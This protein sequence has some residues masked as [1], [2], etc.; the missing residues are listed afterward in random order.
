[1]SNRQEATQEEASGQ[2]GITHQKKRRKEGS[3]NGI[4]KVLQEVRGSCEPFVWPGR[5]RGRVVFACAPLAR[6][7]GVSRRGGG[8]GITISAWHDSRRPIT[9]LAFP[10]RARGASQNG[11]ESGYRLAGRQFVRSTDGKAALP[12]T[13]HAMQIRARRRRSATAA[14]VG[15]VASRGMARAAGRDPRRALH[16]EL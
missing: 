7:E 13:R 16:S 1:M 6:T 14:R 4:L 2:Q 10:G 9:T 3:V 15:D 12:A 11:P 8:G 5:T